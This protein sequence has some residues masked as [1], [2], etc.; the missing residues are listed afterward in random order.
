MKV[1]TAWVMVYFFHTNVAFA[2]APCRTIP[3]GWWPGELSGLVGSTLMLP[4]LSLALSFRYF[5][6]PKLMNNFKTQNRPTMASAVGEAT[7]CA[8]AQLHFSRFSG[9]FWAKWKEKRKRWE[10]LKGWNRG[11]NA[12]VAFKKQRKLKDF[13]LTI[14]NKRR[15]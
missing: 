8:G 7:G 13:E 11:R 1:F 12:F 2:T 10:Q 14:S 6:W 5:R 15:L 4:D 9:L 3:P